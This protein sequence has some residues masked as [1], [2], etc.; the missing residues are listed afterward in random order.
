MG[1]GAA[2]GV[3]STS[4]RRTATPMPGRRS[5]KVT[6][7]T[8]GSWAI[9]RSSSAYVRSRRAANAA[10]VSSPAA[11]VGSRSSVTRAA[12]Y[13]FVGNCPRI[14]MSRH[15]SSEIPWAGIM[16]MTV[17]ATWKIITLVQTHPNRSVEPPAPRFFSFACAWAPVTFSAGKIPSSAAPRIVRP[18]AK[19]TVAGFRPGLTQNGSALVWPE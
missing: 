11:V 15:D 13:S 10:G 17:S 6:A 19:T 14:R 12:R 3:T 5:P 9:R 4:A 7:L 8:P 1:T 2:R 16:Q 18:A